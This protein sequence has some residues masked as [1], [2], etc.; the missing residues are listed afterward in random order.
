MDEMA[1][2]F[3]FAAKAGSLEGYLYHRDE[4]DPL[5]NWVDNILRMHEQLPGRVKKEIGP[6]LEGVLERTL[7]RSGK[8]LDTRNRARLTGLLDSLSK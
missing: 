1:Q 3:L 4:A 7:A 2:L 5:D 6:E 8:G